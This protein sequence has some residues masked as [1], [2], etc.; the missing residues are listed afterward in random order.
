M[1]SAK[2]QRRELTVATCS[3]G[4]KS[5]HQ[6]RHTD[7]FRGPGGAQIVTSRP[8]K[9]ALIVIAAAVYA[10]VGAGLFTIA[11]TKVR[12]GHGMETFLVNSRAQDLT[13]SDALTSSI[14]ALLVPVLVIAVVVIYNWRLKR[15]L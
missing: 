15:G 1:T 4:S 7:S 13:W 11:L 8:I 14:I 6:S 9:I 10:L 3:A 5:A 2:L 12:T